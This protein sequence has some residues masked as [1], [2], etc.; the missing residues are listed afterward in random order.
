MTP[1]K[2]FICYAHE[3]RTTVEGLL[4][5]LRLLEKKE[6]LEIWDDGQILP[7]QDW[8]KSIKRRLENAQLILMFVSV[9]FIN[10]EYIET[11]ELKAALQRHTDGEATLVPIIVRS[12]DWAEYFDIGRFQ[13]LPKQAHPIHSRHFPILDEA[14]HEVAQGIKSLVKGKR[15]QL[16]A[17]AEAERLEQDEKA[18]V[19][20]Q[21]AIEQSQKESLRKQDE[22]AWEAA[23]EAAENAKDE[24][25]KISAYS[26]YW[27]D[28]EHV[29]H[30]AEA[31]KAIGSLKKAEMT[32]KIL[33][34]A[35]EREKQEA[36][37]EKK[38]LDEEAARLK[39]LPEMVFVKGGTFQ[40]GSNE[41]DDAK[42]IHSVTLSDFEIGKYPVTQKLWQEIMGSNPSH[43]KENEN[44]PVENVSS[45]DTQAFLKKLNTR[46]PGR[47]YRLPTEAEW[48]YAA[49]GGTQYKGFEFA[50]SNDPDDVAW[51]NQNAGLKTH[52]VGLKKA[53]ELGI[54]D[55]SGNAWEW[56][57]DWYATYTS[58]SQT[59]PEGPSSGSSHV[60][61]GGSWY[62]GPKYCRVA[63]R[64]SDS[65]TFRGGNIGFRLARTI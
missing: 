64:Y 3:D 34:E 63:G 20:K 57:A 12:C 56:C 59:N 15:D 30:R 5:H 51:Y 58:G 1:L 4:K 26:A 2:T 55:M 36:A 33:L 52:P 24:R 47:Q 8:D 22:A 45:E 14:L 50:G 48:E 6:L 7:G 54:Y 46:F 39:D 18:K 32:R 61:R 35:T 40:M 43:F 49:R 19:E 23:Q 25:G 60:L 10:S 44:C 27:N 9:D 53:N 31:E 37:A 17:K 42:P 41:I 62:G 11:T 38:R 13:A 29:I 65:P 16:A 21:A 28:P